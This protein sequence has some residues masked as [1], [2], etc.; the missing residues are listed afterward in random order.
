MALVL[1]R[2]AIPPMPARVLAYALV[3]D[4][5]IHT[6]G[7]FAEDLRVSPA[8]I[9]VAMHQLMDL[10]LVERTREPGVRSDLYS[11]AQPRSTIE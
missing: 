4:H 8:A 2:L 5:D 1:R 11:L 7:E 3:A 6:A 10:G 9:S